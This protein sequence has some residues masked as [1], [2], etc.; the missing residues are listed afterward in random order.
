LIS[1][2]ITCAAVSAVFGIV[3]YGILH[4][5]NLGQRPQGTL[6][7]LDDVLGPADGRDRPGDRPSHFRQ[8]GPHVGGA[9]PAALGVA[10]AVTFT[11]GAAI[12]ACA[13]VALLFALKD[14]RLFAILPILRRSSSRSRPGRSPGAISRCST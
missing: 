3:Q 10:V 12:G 9:G 13:A 7:A 8:H 14:F 4:Y 5:D 2:V 1:V 11:R 6:G